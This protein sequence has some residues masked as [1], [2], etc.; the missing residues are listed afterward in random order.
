MTT[1]HPTA[2]SPRS[3]ANSAVRDESVP[4]DVVWRFRAD[5]EGAW[6]ACSSG[7]PGADF[8]ACRCGTSGLAEMPERLWLEHRRVRRFG[9][10]DP[11]PSMRDAP[12]RSMLSCGWMRPWMRIQ[13]PSFTA[14]SLGDGSSFRGRVFDAAELRKS[15]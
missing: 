5:R 3:G 8:M 4:A 6:C 9:I 12:I 2:S 15:N 1:G 10:A 14:I 13:P 11:V 7:D